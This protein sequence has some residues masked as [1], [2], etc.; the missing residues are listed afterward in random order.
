[1][2]ET[3]SETIA[4]WKRYPRVKYSN[5]G[6]L[7]E[8]PEHWHLLKLKF[9]V[10]FYGGG[11]PAKENLDYWNGEIPWVSPKDMKSEN[12]EDTEDHITEIA[13]KSS[14]TRVVPTGSVLLVVRSGILRHS[15]PVA[16]NLRPLAINQDMKALVPTKS[17]AASFLKYF[18]IGNQESLLVEWRK[19]GT[20]VES[21]EHDLLASTQCLVPQRS[22]QNR[23]A[24]FLDHET[25]KIDALIAKKERLIGLLKEKR[26]ALIS[27]A[28]TKGLDPSVPM[29]DSGVEWLGDVPDHWEMRRLKYCVSLIN[30]KA[31]DQDTGLLH[32]GLE[33][34]ESWTG[35]LI[36]QSEGILFSE[37]QS[38]LFKSGD[39]L[40]GKLRP[41]LA[42]VLRA[43]EEGISTGELLV[44]RP[45]DVI[46]D[47]LFYYMLAANFIHVVDSSTYGAKMP[48]A[49]W[50]FMGNLPMLRPEAEEQ[51]DIAAFLDSEIA[52][53]DALSLKIKNT[54]EKLEEYRTALIY[55]AVTGKIDVRDKVCL[56]GTA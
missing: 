44:I 17:L 42:K 46:Q 32:I 51:R 19:N 6:W 54:I 33:N 16:I 49:N 36:Q 56:G 22:E 45:R 53:I 28:V 7:G 40:F 27:H 30:M 8:V 29:K 31:N 43:K 38:N 47:F 20:T 1:M 18:F 3:A 2:T 48:R 26:A 10:S 23:I 13:V 21:I 35:R 5:V 25:A 39:V 14:A 12:I 4:E 37:G 41:Y 15:I 11:T 55:A 24:T 52:K 9:A 50:G 34:V